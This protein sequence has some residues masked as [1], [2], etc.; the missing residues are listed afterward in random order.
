MGSDWD[1][2]FYRWVVDHLTVLTNNFKVGCVRAGFV[3]NGH[4]VTC[5]SSFRW[6]IMKKACLANVSR[7]M[8]GGFPGYELGDWENFHWNIEPSKD[9]TVRT[10]SKDIPFRVKIITGHHSQTRAHVIGDLYMH[11]LG[12]LQ[13]N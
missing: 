3:A 4:Q 1:G 6:N 7:C 2:N 9:V 12:L 5:T 13:N 8:W 11:S 10:S